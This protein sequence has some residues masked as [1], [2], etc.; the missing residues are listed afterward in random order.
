MDDIGKG[1]RK[2][3]KFAIISSLAFLITLSFLFSTSSA[4]AACN[5]YRDND[6]GA[7]NSTSNSYAPKDYWKYQ[8]ASTSYRGDHRINTNG[9]IS[10]AGGYP[11]Y[12]WKFSQRCDGYYN[13]SIYINSFS[14]VDTSATY[15]SNN[16][17]ITNGAT[18]NQFNAPGSWFKIGTFYHGVSDKGNTTITLRPSS[19]SRGTGADGVYIYE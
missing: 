5:Q 1:G 12:E 2:M 16:D 9:S 8:S 11:Y 6:E 13:V 4:D 15:F 14:F 10:P 18:V 3:K 19:S 7:I 17:N